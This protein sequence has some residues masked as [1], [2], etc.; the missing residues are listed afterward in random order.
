MSEWQPI[1]TA[2]RDGTAIW[3]WLNQM[4]IRR[5]RYASPEE[6]A[7]TDGGEPDE[8]DGLWVEVDDD[9]EDW[10]PRYW[11]PLDAIPSPVAA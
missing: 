5:L 1:E 4:G 6:L 10:S 2:P 11:L 7:A 3:A 8:Y 9:D